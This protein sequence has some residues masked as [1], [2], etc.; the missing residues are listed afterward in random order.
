MGSLKA[1]CHPRYHCSHDCA[2]ALAVG[3]QKGQ[4]VHYIMQIIGCAN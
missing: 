3:T 4:R 1:I 2:S